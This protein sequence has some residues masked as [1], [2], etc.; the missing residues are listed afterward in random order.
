MPKATF[1]FPAGFLWGSAAAAHC[2]EGSSPAT[3]W[4]EWEQ[5]PGRIVDGSTVGRGCEW[6]SVRWREDFDRAQETDQKALRFS[7]ESL[8]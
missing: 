6:W 2:V 8:G 1:N 5:Q 4:L 7:I 3:D